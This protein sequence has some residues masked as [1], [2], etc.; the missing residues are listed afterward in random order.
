MLAA[1]RCIQFVS[2]YMDYDNPQFIAAVRKILKDCLTQ[3]SNSFN[4]LKESVSAHWQADEKRYQTKP[5]AVTDLRTDVPI[6]VKTYAQRDTKERIWGVIKG[7]LEVVVAIAVIGYTAISYENW[8]QQIDATNF[9]ARQTELSRKGLNETRKNFVINQ[10]AWVGVW[11]QLMPRPPD[12]PT[13]VPV[14]AVFWR[15]VW[16]N[17]GPTPALYAQ[18]TP[19]VMYKQRD[20]VIDSDFSEKNQRHLNPNWKGASHAVVLPNGTGNSPTWILRSP[21]PGKHLFLSGT[22]TYDDIFR[23]SHTTTY[24]QIFDAATQTLEDCNI[25]NTMN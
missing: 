7:A 9:A 19:G 1:P 10:R 18:V 8:L 22:L 24:C 23:G 4:D 25:R 21:E 11:A 15:V 2:S 6:S 3:L 12:T 17:T 16:K 13:S 14:D 20:Y 5:V